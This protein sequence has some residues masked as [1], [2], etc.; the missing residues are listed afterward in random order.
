M[1]APITEY[2]LPAFDITLSVDPKELEKI[3]HRATPML[4]VLLSFTRKGAGNFEIRQR[5]ISLEFSII[6]RW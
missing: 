5:R 2:H 3:P 1:A 4:G 6:A